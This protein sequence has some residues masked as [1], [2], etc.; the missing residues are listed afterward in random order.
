VLFLWPERDTG[1]ECI[2]WIPAGIP[3]QEAEGVLKAYGFT[4]RGGDVECEAHF[5][6]TREVD[7]LVIYL[8]VARQDGATGKE[9]QRVGARWDPV[10]W[11]WRWMYGR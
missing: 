3:F 10:E 4:F 6:F 2:D 1:Q 5:K 7:G 9:L 8:S 11:V